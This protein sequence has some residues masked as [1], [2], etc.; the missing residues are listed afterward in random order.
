M[1]SYSEDKLNKIFDK[2]HGACHLCAKKLYFSNY[3]NID[4]RRGKWEVEHSIPKA[5]GGTDHLNNLYAACISC[6][7]S[8]GKKTTRT[9]RA[10]HGRTKAPHSAEK[11]VVIRRNSTVGWGITGLALT[12]L[13]TSNPTTLLIAAL[14]SGAFGNSLNPND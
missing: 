10:I 12:A 14:T 1:A 4:G 7:R 11:K 3:G 5:K 9:I 8:K 6:N 13:V 2:T